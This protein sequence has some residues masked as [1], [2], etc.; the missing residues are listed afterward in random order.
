V[1]TVLV[2]GSKGFIGKHV[3]EAL[4]RSPDTEVICFYRGMDLKAISESLPRVSV[5]Y[6]LAGVNRPIDPAEF[7]NGN[8]GLTV[9]LCRLLSAGGSR[10]VVVYASTV[11]AAL[12]NPYGQSKR[13]AEEQLGNWARAEGGRAVIFRLQ[14]VFGKWCRPN[15]NSVVAT[16]CHN[17]ARDI[18]ISI[19][20]PAKEL[21]LV[22]IDD[23]VAALIDAAYRPPGSGKCV[24]ASVQ[25]THRVT[26]GRIAETLHAFRGM[27]TTLTVPD[28]SDEFTRCLYGTYVSYLEADK[29]A[30][31]LQQR[32][33][34][35]GTL[36]EFVKQAGFGQ[37]FV[38]R[39]FPGITRGNHYHHTKTE[40]FLVLE[41]DAVVRFRA[42][43]GG[44]VIE[45]PVRGADLKV[46]DIPTGYTH[47]IENVGQTELITLFW[48]SEVF[49]PTAP[50]TIAS[51]VLTHILS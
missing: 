34:P 24:Q 7:V 5:V 15:Y 22:Y 13:Q 35:R 51:N 17:I 50:D 45:Y 19:S 40:K 2:T 30:Y 49:N 48:S 29:F 26:L 9:D 37:I 10:P 1:K 16:F 44:D 47:S 27:R 3:V 11:Q 23:V 46:V 33:D 25:H 21:E 14:N 20:D 4:R 31:D 28:M 32:S 36:A 39:T 38:S 42:I 41:G 43:L 8:H 6:H 18:P 12:D